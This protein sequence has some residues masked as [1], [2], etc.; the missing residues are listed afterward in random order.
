V[1]DF[2][3]LYNRSASTA[4][5]LSGYRLSGVGFTF[6]EGVIIPPRGY[7]LAVENL[8]TFTTTY[9]S[10]WPVAGVY[11]GR[12]DNGGETLGRAP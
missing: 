11:A 2:I 10:G 6:P 7:L 8:A 3:E 1:V 9:G 4:F 12:L 5:N